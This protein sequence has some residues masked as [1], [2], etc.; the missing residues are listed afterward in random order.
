M[1]IYSLT[2]QRLQ[3]FHFQVFLFFHHDPREEFFFFWTHFTIYSSFLASCTLQFFEFATQNSS[4]HLNLPQFPQYNPLHTTSCV[5][6]NLT[7]INCRLIVLYCLLWF[8]NA[9][10][11]VLVPDVLLLDVQMCLWFWGVWYFCLCWF[12]DGLSHR[13]PLFGRFCLYM[14]V[15]VVRLPQPYFHWIVWRLI[16]CFICNIPSL[17]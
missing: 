2:P 15:V 3:I 16:F 5:D 9:L 12:M 4:Y 6:L 10:N 13:T 11:T 1:S 7:Q 17:L 8:I 14:F